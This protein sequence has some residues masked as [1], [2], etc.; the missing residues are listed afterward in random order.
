METLEENFA[1]LPQRLQTLIDAKHPP[2]HNVSMLMEG[3][4]HHVLLWIPDV[5]A[6][7]CEKFTFPELFFI[8]NVFFKKT[9]TIT[10]NQN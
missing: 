6:S 5:A 2:L 8:F 10:K 3:P 1:A 4:R 7:G 9:K